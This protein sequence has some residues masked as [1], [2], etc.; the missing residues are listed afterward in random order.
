M[1]VCITAPTRGDDWIRISGEIRYPSRFF[2]SGLLLFT[3]NSL[4]IGTDTKG[5]FKLPL[6]NLKASPEPV[7]G[8][9]RFKVNGLTVY[10]GYLYAGTS[11]GVYRLEGQSWE[12]AT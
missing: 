12:T 1:M 8:L 2:G 6:A 3:R 10:A 4:W 5:V 9:E 11:R 7:P